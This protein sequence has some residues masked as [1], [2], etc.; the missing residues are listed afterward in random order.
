MI[1]DED[2]I[3]S[4]NEFAEQIIRSACNGD[5]EAVQN[6]TDNVMKKL[7]IDEKI[8]KHHKNIKDT[9][10]HINMELK[11]KKGQK[12]SRIRIDQLKKNIML[13]VR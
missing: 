3:K 6:L 8:S 4:A 10:I 13:N 5:Q 1:E 9:I 2:A 12:P 11:S 7:K